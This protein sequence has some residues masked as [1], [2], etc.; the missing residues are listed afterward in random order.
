[1]A[2]PIQV[3]LSDGREFTSIAALRR[4]V[5]IEL[6][7]AGHPCLAQGNF[8]NRLK[9]YRVS[10]VSNV[11][12]IVLSLSL[13]EAVEIARADTQDEDGGYYIVRFGGGI[14]VGITVLFIHERLKKHLHDAKKTGRK[15]TFH[16]AIIQYFGK[17]VSLDVFLKGVDEFIFE[18]NLASDT[19]VK[20]EA[21]LVER[22]QEEGHFKIYN[23]AKTGSLHGRV[24]NDLVK[25]GQ[26]LAMY[27]RDKVKTLDLG[28]LESMKAFEALRQ[29]YYARIKKLG[30]SLTDQ[31]KVSLIDRLMKGRKL[32][33]RFIPENADRFVFDGERQSIYEIAYTLDMS[34]AALKSHLVRR[35][36]WS[37]SNVDIRDVFER[38]EKYPLL[39]AKHGFSEVLEYLRRKKGEED[40]VVN[41]LITYQSTIDEATLAGF[42]GYLGFPKKRNSVYNQLKKLDVEKAS[43]GLYPFFKKHL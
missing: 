15:N 23:D 38:A 26:Y 6:E 10:D 39:K 9:K 41:R 13:N 29:R 18:A 21:E 14:Y 25:P 28:D 12:E 40:V 2:N 11:T 7:Q 36:I 27:M 37:K 24:G 16:Q 43:E 33:G 5:E 1:M 3:R 8:N 17:K 19:L 31:D 22:Y 42:I 20:K 32:L 34:R 30:V 35:G 4:E